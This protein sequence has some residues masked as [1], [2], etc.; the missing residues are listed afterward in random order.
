MSEMNVVPLRNDASAAE[1]HAFFQQLIS[2]RN[3]IPAVPTSVAADE[4]AGP[5]QAPGIQEGVGSSEAEGI[6]SEGSTGGQDVRATL[7]GV[8]KEARGQAQME[9]IEAAA[10]NYTAFQV[11]TGE[12]VALVK[13]GRISVVPIRSEAFQRRLKI[14]LFQRTGKAPSA[15]YLELMVDLIADRAEHGVMRRIHKRVAQDGGDV[16]IDLGDESGQRLR[17]SGDDWQVEPGDERVLFR[18]ADSYGL[19]EVPEHVDDARVAW[20]WL[21]PLLTRVPKQAHF[22]LVAW[23]VTS[24][25]CEAD[26][27]IVLLIGPEGSAKSTLA[28]HLT[29]VFDPPQGLVPTVSPDTPKDIVAGAQRR[30]VCVLDN[31]PGHLGKGVEDVLC[32]ISTGAQID[33]RAYYT[34]FDVASAELHNP[35]IVTAIT[36]PFRQR[37]S[38]NRTIAVEIEALRDGFKRRADATDEIEHRMGQIRGAVLYFLSAYLRRRDAILASEKIPHR[39][40]DWCVAGEAIIRELGVEPGR[41]LAQVEGLQR[42]DAREYLEGDLAGATLID[43]LHRWA[44]KAQPADEIPPI[45]QWSDGWAAVQSTSGEVTIVAQPARLQK[46]LAVQVRS[47]MTAKDNLPGTARAMTGTIQRLQ[48]VLGRAGVQATPRRAAAG[49]YWEF[50]SRPEVLARFI[51][52]TR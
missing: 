48:G 44:S 10:G 41:F 29:K 42:T 27:P 50:I 47:N 15:A 33:V 36:H 11:Q 21:Q 16:V 4:A 8:A 46:E 3:P 43:V 13:N 1:K 31:A 49:R 32:Q 19:I 51:E 6:A 24:V 45:S 7:G 28:Q 40:V 5:T 23:L 26:F 20:Q 2:D 38:R 14:D 25:L 12:I 17:V 39:M 18:R 52:S 30:H 37:D 9:E 22:N 34:N 35:L